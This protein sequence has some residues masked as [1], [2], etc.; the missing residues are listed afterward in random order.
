MLTQAIATEEGIQISDPRSD[1]E[2]AYPEAERIDNAGLTTLF[3]LP[4]ETGQLLIEVAGS[5]VA[6]WQDD[7]DSV[8]Y[9]RVIGIDQEPVGIAATDDVVG[10]CTDRN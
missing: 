2:A 1:V 10:L 9:L 5:D 8:V 3:V 4:G 6:Y 7:A